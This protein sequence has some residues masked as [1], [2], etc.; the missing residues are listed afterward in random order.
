MSSQR[1]RRVALGILILAVCVVLT[2][3]LGFTWEI[4]ARVRLWEA[5]RIADQL[6]EISNTILLESKTAEVRNNIPKCGVVHVDRKK[7]TGCKMCVGACPFG[8]MR[9]IEGVATKCDQCN[10]SPYCV[11]FC[12]ARALTYGTP[13]QL[14]DVKQIVLSDKILEMSKDNLSYARK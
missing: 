6:P 8:A 10:G 13:Q 14:S 3:V 11:E 2:D 12:R 5:E 1:V 9:F 4:R 7:C